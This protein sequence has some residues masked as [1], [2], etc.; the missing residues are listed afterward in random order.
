MTNEE[1]IEAVRHCI[2]C[3]AE[4]TSD[5][6][7]AK[8]DTYMDNIIVAKIPD[9]R[10]WIAMTAS[11][12]PYLSAD[13][14]A[15]AATSTVVIDSSS[16]QQFTDVKEAKDVGVVT[17]PSKIEA[18]N[19]CW[20]RCSGWH[21]AAIPN[22]D[23]SDAALAMFD[24]TAKGTKERPQAVIMRTSPLKILIQPYT[25][26]DSE[27]SL[28]FVGISSAQDESGDTDMPQKLRSA[29]IYYI[30]HLLLSAYG[31]NRA[32]VMYN[33]AVQQLGASVS[34]KG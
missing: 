29:F 16:V 15:E 10:H 19:V 22:E 11:Q 3:E 30:A 28:S 9:A 25:G 17:L 6:T 7:A 27:V 34:Q 5:I 24:E 32:Q 14:K 20:V 33:I 8:D 4:N 18:Y 1:I 26:E 13:S 31:D 12:S 23:T 2:D 21:K